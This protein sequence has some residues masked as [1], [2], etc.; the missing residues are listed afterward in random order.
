MSE[1]TNV[2]RLHEK[3][4]VVTALC[5]LAPGVPLKL[6]EIGVVTREL[7]PFGYKVAI[8]SIA[9]GAYVMKYGVAIGVAL[10]PISPGEVV[11]THNLKS[12]AERYE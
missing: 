1:E 3:D 6:D 7:I 9:P 5:D 10:R 2:I 12:L 11:H 8:Q 4:N